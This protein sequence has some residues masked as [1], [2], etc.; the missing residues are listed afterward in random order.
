[1]TSNSESIAQRLHGELDMLISQVSGPAGGQQS[2]HAAEEQLWTGMLAMGRGLMQLCLN[3][4][5][6]AEVV[7]DV[8]E[9]QGAVYRYQGSRARGY[10]SLFGEVHVERAYYWSAD[11]GGVCPLD[12]ALSLPERCYSDRVQERLS[13]VS[14]RGPPYHRFALFE[15]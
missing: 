3:A 1:M 4:R 13:E 14:A 10:V 9:V 6:E 12:A 8:L 11:W 15:G 5:S 7:Q 2:A